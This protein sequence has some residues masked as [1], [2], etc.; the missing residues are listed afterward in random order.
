[1]KRRAYGGEMGEGKSGEIVS[2]L[3]ANDVGKK[4]DQGGGRVGGSVGGG[5]GGGGGGEG[6]GRERERVG[7]GEACNPQE[8]F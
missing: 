6:S 8:A 5:G 1:M 2:A 7:A 4:E 3:S